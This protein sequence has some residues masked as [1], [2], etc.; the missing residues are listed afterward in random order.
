MGA[1]FFQ[2]HGL[3]PEKKCSRSDR[4]NEMWRKI[5]D[6]SVREYKGE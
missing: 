5:P 1:I 4:W 3:T 6:K 2:L